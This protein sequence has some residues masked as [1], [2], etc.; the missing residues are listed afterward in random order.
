MAGLS[1]EDAF[2]IAFIAIIFQARAYLSRK[3]QWA[4]FVSTRRVACT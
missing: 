3:A 1:E 2:I 4:I